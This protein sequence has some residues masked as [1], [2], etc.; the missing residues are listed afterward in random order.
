MGQLTNFLIKKGKESLSNAQSKYEAK[1]KLQ[2]E[3]AAKMREEAKERQARHLAEIEEV[4]ASMRLPFAGV[5]L[6][7]ICRH[8]LAIYCP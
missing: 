7:N 4:F 2:Q 8:V 1:V 6:G 3:K 5:E